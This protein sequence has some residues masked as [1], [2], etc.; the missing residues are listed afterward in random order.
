MRK[1]TIFWI[2]IAIFIV[3]SVAGFSSLIF[4][5]KNQEN[6]REQVTN[7][8]QAIDTDVLP[9]KKQE[10]PT[11]H[12]VVRALEVSLYQQGTHYL[13]DA[14]TGR[15][16]ALLDTNNGINLD[17]YIDKEVDVYGPVE[18]T[19]EGDGVIM[20]VERVEK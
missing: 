4:S 15:V 20:D 14:V 11:Y 5:E 1:N 19:I 12:G 18:R 8:Q 17:T 2:I 9:A 6:V 13:E 7:R 3:G 10:K 16:L